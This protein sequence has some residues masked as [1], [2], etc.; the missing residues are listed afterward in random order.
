MSTV[1][2]AV[3]ADFEEELEV[4]KINVDEEKEKADKY[5]IFS[6]PTFVLEKD[7]KEVARTSGARSKEE[8]AK[9]IEEH[10]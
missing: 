8:F 2:D 3:A 1:I 9:W 10:L 5:E 7:G 6:I 4:V